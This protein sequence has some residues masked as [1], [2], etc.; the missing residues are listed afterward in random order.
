VNGQGI[1]QGTEGRRAIFIARRKK[2]HGNYRLLVLIQLGDPHV[3]FL[4]FLFTRALL[5]LAR[6]LWFR[7]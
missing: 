2:F 7:A 4:S 6:L 5:W 1:E 3:F